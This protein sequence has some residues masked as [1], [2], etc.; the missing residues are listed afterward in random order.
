MGANINAH[1]SL[2][3][4]FPIIV[5]SVVKEKSIVYH[6]LFVSVQVVCKKISM[7]YSFLKECVSPNKYVTKTKK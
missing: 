3:G 7:V 5:N 6:Y 4:C 2:H 1:Q